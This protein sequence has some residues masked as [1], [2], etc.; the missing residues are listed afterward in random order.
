MDTDKGKKK[1]GIYCL[2]GRV[3]RGARVFTFYLFIC[4]QIKRME[5]I[6]LF[7]KPN[8]LSDTSM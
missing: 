3:C 5:W 6:D 2:H 4:P 7:F 8:D 1:G